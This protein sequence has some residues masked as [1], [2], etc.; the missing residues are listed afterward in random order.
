MLQKI[1]ESF[2]GHGITDEKV[3]D[4]TIN[5]IRNA[6]ITYAEEACPGVTRKFIRNIS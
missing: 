2:I 3:I 5:H 4:Q 1:K 6:W